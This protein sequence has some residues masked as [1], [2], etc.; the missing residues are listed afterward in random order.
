VRLKCKVDDY[1]VDSY[2][3]ANSTAQ[4]QELAQR[5]SEVS[6][7]PVLGEDFTGQQHELNDLRCHAWLTKKY[8]R[9]QS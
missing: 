2:F 5:L 1:L 3:Y 8:G 9:L 7:L 6:G 4:A